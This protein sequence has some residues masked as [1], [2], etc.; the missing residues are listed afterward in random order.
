MTYYDGAQDVA[1]RRRCGCIRI[2]MPKGAA[3]V[4][5]PKHAARYQRRFDQTEQQDAAEVTG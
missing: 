2:R 1:T 5:C 4:P 3:Y